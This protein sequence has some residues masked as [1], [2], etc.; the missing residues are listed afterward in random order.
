MP[1]VI[2]P[3]MG[4]GGFLRCVQ[5]SR[6]EVLVGLPLAVWLARFRRSHFASLQHKL[7]VGRSFY[8]RIGDYSS[9]GAFAAVDS[10]ENDLAA[11]L[12][13][14]GSTGPA[15]GVCYTHGMFAAQVEMIREQY[16]IMPGEI[17]LPM[18]PVFALFNPALGMC[19]VVPEMNP[20]PTCESRS[21]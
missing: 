8:R 15:K 7:A 3:G 12:F 9:N 20:E 6:P 17:D 13:T 11:I 5:H 21:G 16:A 14:S 19:T 2:D 1:V 10:E 4:L 18:L